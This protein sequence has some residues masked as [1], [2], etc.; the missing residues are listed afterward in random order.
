MKPTTAIMAAFAAVAATVL[1]G[2]LST[3]VD[4]VS[5]GE[6]GSLI[7]Q[8]TSA[9][10]PIGEQANTVF[11]V[12]EIPVPGQ[13]T[14]EVKVVNQPAP[15]PQ[16][17]IVANLI[18]QN[19]VQDPRYRDNLLGLADYLAAEL[20]DRGIRCIIPDNAMGV[21]QNKGPGGE[22]LR[23]SSAKGQSQAVGAECFVTASIRSFTTRRKGVPPQQ[24]VVPVLRMSLNVADSATAV[25]GAG[26][27]VTIEIPPVSVQNYET[28]AEDF[29]QTVLEA[30]ASQCAAKIEP[31]VRS[32]RIATAPVLATI[33]LTC[34]V[35]GADVRI[36]GF[37]Y[38]TAPVAIKL[39]VGIHDVEI[40]YPFCVPYRARANV[41]DGQRYNV[42][43]E[44]TEM[45]RARYKDMTL[46][47]EIIDRIRKTGA[48]D[49]YV[50]RVVA[51]GQGEFLKNS[52]F[53]WDGAL[54]TLTVERTGVPPVVFGPT[55]TTVV[56]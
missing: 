33:E 35:A 22:D 9:S 36:D 7:V 54:H 18:V 53:R 19:H 37:S 27:N 1:A 21:N 13:Q 16:D 49:D 28:N 14:I 17:D 11:M 43:L 56:K 25:T 8:K 24:I 34:N 40:L 38:G 31:K 52:Y 29:Y 26:E 6:D 2:E 44:L 30:A 45:G 42:N 23:G 5:V 10:V 39:P 4:T 15:P 32:R 51:D 41:Q 46:F 20:A 3:S 12:P 55:T 48:T 47:A 50:R